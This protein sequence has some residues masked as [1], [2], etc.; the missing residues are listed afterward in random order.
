MDCIVAA[1]GLPKPEEPLYAFTQGKSKALLDMNGRTMLE[2]VMDALQTAHHVDRIVVIGLENDMGMTFQRPIDQYLPDH[3]SMVGNILAG[4]TWLRE[5][6]PTIETVLFCSADVPMITG[7]IV[8]AHIE[9][10][11]PM[12]K[13]VYYTFVT[14]ETM[15]RRFPGSNRT[16]VKLKGVEIA[17]GDLAIAQ[18]VVADHNEE[19]FH[20][21]TNAR[22]HAWKLARIVGFKFLIKFLFRQVSISDI[23]QTAERILGMPAQIVLTPFA[24][25]AMDADKPEQ[26]DLLRGELRK[27]NA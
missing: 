2:R 8:D 27:G 13:A 24:E 26:V 12:D 21:L 6:D 20:T 5:T 3:G 25:I 16:Y 4:I 9:S 14:R 18:V 15:E 10:C 19:L 23:E 11:Q 22:K 7:S 1:G 17:G